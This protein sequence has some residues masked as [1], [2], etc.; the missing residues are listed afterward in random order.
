MTFLITRPEHD[1][2]T[3]YLSDYSKK[4]IAVA[5]EKGIP[6]FDCVNK[7]ANKK[8]VSSLLA[9]KKPKFIMFN[10][11]G[12]A[13][14]ITGNK[15]EPLI[16]LGEDEDLIKDAIVYARVCSSGEKLGKSCGDN[17]SGAYIGYDKKFRFWICSTSTHHP[18]EDRYAKPFL[19]ASNQVA[20]SL[21]KGASA[22][23]A[24]D[25]SQAAFEQY[26]ENL[27]NSDSPKELR[28]LLPLL[29]WDKEIQKYYGKKDIRMSD[30]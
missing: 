20:I 15:L 13:E 5:E 6:V 26:I 25:R 30:M 18:Q 12:S 16:R 3:L 23:E 1:D 19:D 2:E 28:F 27:E 21:L 7:S 14:V 17:G 24:Y 22:E 11:H 10:G 8:K 9:S 4:I 29:Y